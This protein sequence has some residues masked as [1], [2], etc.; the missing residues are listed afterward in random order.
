MA[1]W[2]VLPFVLLALCIVAYLI[3]DYRRKAAQRAQVS[4]ERLTAILGQADPMAA[5]MAGVRG[6]ANP[7]RIEPTAQPLTP[8]AMPYVSRER[9]LGPPE[10]LLYLLLKTGMPDYH[11]FAQAALRGILDVAPSAAAYARNEHLRRL[12][13]HAVDFLVCDRAL[14]PVAVI[15]IVGTGERNAASVAREAWIKAAGLHYLALQPNALPRKE[16]LRAMVL[17]GSAG[18]TQRAAATNS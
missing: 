9:V 14:R 10:T 18:S 5:A 6:E 2:Y 17:A 16:A 4:A 13:S 3:W 8:A 12:A 7:A 1:N 15:E 11:V